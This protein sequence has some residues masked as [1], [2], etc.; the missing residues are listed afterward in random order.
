MCYN[1][2]LFSPAFYSLHIFSG[3]GATGRLLYSVSMLSP[4]HKPDSRALGVPRWHV[5]YC[6]KK[7]SILFTNKSWEE[8]IKTR[9][10]IFDSVKNIWNPLPST[11]D[12]FSPNWHWT[13]YLGLMKDKSLKYIW[14]AD[15][16][17]IPYGKAIRY[18]TIG[19][20]G[21]RYGKTEDWHKCARNDV[22][23]LQNDLSCTTKVFS[24]AGKSS[25]S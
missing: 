14:L 15:S 25:K 5:G 12:W 24:Q 9:R 19:Q 22:K 7:S 17:R 23:F 3:S 20:N 8:I 21:I 16:D 1:T 4:F 6:Q 11:A 2:C 18:Q 13:I 10:W